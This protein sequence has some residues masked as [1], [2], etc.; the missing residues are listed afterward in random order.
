MTPHLMTCSKAEVTLSQSLVMSGRLAVSGRLVVKQLTPGYR[1]YNQVK[2][3]F[4]LCYVCRS[5]AG[6][7]CS[8]SSLPGPV[9]WHRWPPGPGSGWHHSLINSWHS[10]R[11]LQQ[12]THSS[13]FH[14]SSRLSPL[15]ILPSSS[16]FPSLLLLL[17]NWSEDLMKTKD[18][19]PDIRGNALLFRP[20]P[21]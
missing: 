3:C 15:F 5:G 13:C 16:S 18:P 14:A 4:S 2:L 7:C 10:P 1:L 11:S 20:S 21:L 19:C 17:L 8:P 9:P 12:K 6:G